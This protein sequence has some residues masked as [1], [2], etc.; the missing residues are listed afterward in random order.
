MRKPLEE[1]GNA[2]ESAASRGGGGGCRFGFAWD[3]GFSFGFALLANAALGVG[4]FFLG[5]RG[6]L[7]GHGHIVFSLFVVSGGAGRGLEWRSG[8]VG[9]RLY[10]SVLVKW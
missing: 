1:P 2:V 6:L 3:P 9:H 5:G 4:F 10:S 8:V 7:D